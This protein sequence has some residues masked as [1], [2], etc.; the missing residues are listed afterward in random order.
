MCTR[1]GWSGAF[2]NGGRRVE[3]QR[4]CAAAQRNRAL[5]SRAVLT[6]G[7]RTQPVAEVSHRFHQMSVGRRIAQLLAQAMYQLL[8]QLTIAPGPLAPD[9]VQHPLGGHRHR[10]ERLSRKVRR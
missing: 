5:A 3:P 2:R 4:P 6:P 10:A 1:A 8:E 9:M 7:R